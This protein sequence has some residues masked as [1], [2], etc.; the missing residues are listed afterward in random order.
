MVVGIVYAVEGGSPQPV[1]RAFM[2]IG[3]AIIAI[4]RQPA[5][6]LKHWKW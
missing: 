6:T 5:L 4:P 1:P 2:A 3:Q